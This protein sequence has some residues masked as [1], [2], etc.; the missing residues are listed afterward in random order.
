L[1]IIWNAAAEGPEPEYK[2]ESEYP[3]WVFSMIEEKPLL[4]DFIMKGLEK[5]PNE[6]MKMVFR[7]ANKRQIKEGNNARRKD[8]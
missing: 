7:M 4:E 3:P 8:S 6:K 1:A 5:V 2:A